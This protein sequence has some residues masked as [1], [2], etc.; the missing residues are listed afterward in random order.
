MNKFVKNFNNL[1]NQTI[2]IVRNN[3]INKSKISNFNKCLITLI[4]LLF[5]YLFYLSV[6][7]LYEKTWVQKN[8]ENQ[9]FKEFRIN[10]SIS[11][12]ISYRILPAPHFLVKDSKIFKDDSDKKTSLADIRKLKIFI[13]QD[14]FFD[15]EEIT[16]KYV[17][18]DDAN[19]SLSK[20]DFKLLKK[21]FNNKLSEKRIEINHGNIFFKNNL[22]KPI[23][24][25]KISKAFLF[26]DNKN[27][28]NLFNLK[29]K[30][31]N[32]PFK[33]DYDKKFDSLK[34]EKIN[35]SAKKL[36]INISDIRD[37]KENNF[38]NGV[39]IISFLNSRINTNYKI[40]DGLVSFNSNVSKIENIKV[41]YNGELSINPFD[42]NLHITIYDFQLLKLL[43]V[44]QI[45]KELIQTQLL[46]N[47]NISVN[48]SI[49]TS[50]NL[51]KEIFQDSKINFNIVNGKINFNK[52]KLINK[53]IGFLE[54]DNSNL[55]FDNERL[56]LSTDILVDIK[57]SDELFSLLQTRKK[58]RKPIR[59]ILINLDYDFLTK[60]I[61]FN[62]FKIGNKEASNELSRIIE[63][64]SDNKFNNWNNSKRVLNAF[65]KIYEG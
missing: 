53:K 45:L 24:F 25:I 8:I 12:D 56:I 63:G 15:K 31:F 20:D 36:N 30:V 39:N 13:T 58:F 23:T 32:I 10:F 44:N 64:F 11:S 52:T 34:S 57:N 60:Q 5:F 43:K 55:R 38:N 26:F 54:L 46:F 50:S 65:F 4:S 40:D 14:S 19:F 16:I 2:F 37:N 51:K 28:L 49:I 59:N 17:K 35:I 9:L 62:S 47:D 3:T 29:G 27:L 18:I 21:N 1:I 61:V 22:N 42:L 41:E 7:I 6:P 48:T 33:L